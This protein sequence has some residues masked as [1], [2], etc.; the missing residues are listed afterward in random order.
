MSLVVLTS[1]EGSG[2]LTLF[3][4]NPQPPAKKLLM[5]SVSVFPE[6]NKN[7]DEKFSYIDID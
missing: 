7:K 2:A 3:P 6:K 1:W 4:K 5:G